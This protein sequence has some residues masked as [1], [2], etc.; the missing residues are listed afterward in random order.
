[1]KNNKRFN[2]MLLTA[3]CTSFLS[4][5]PASASGDETFV[6]DIGSSLNQFNS[7]IKV[8]G[9]SRGTKIDLEDDLN[10]D[11]ETNIN[12]I[13]VAWR[14]ADKHRLSM[15]YTPI[16][17]DSTAI[18]DEDIE[19][20]DTVIFADGVV[21]AKSEIDI[22]DI[23][24][25]YSFYRSDKFEA[26]LSTGIYWL[27]LDFSLEASGLIMNEEGVVAIQD[28]YKNKVSAEA[29][30]PLI[31]ISATYQ[32]GRNW[33]LAANLRYFEASIGDY[34]GDIYSAQIRTNYYVTNNIGLGLSLASFSLNVAADDPDW[35][36]AFGWDF[37]A[38]EAYL[39]MRF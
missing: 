16:N 35:D 22:F 33:D 19:F 20:Q 10:F 24:Y 9:S 28:D 39:T 17:R 14:F 25:T 11:D 30:L 32:L 13:K 26:G 7:D 38:L 27:S 1:M 36:G 15:Q 21:T 5:N 18:L 23:N 31:G 34:N 8:N 2:L 12:V 3:I 4:S 37:T 6:I 29:P